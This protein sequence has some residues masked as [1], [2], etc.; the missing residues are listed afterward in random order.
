MG[1]ECTKSNADFSKVGNL[2][3]AFGE[4]VTEFTPEEYLYVDYND[5]K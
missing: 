1:V 4:F 5:K 3:I 2:K